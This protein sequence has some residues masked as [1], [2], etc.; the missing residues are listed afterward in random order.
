MGKKENDK[1]KKKQAKEE[2]N[3]KKAELDKIYGF[4]TSQV[5]GTI[6]I[7]VRSAMTMRMGGREVPSPINFQIKEVTGNIPPRVGIINALLTG[8]ARAV[9]NTEVPVANKEKEK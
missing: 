8:A 5:N 4:D 3:T 9:L 6:T 2:K 7:E 1:K